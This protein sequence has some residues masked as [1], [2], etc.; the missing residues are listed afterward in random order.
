MN[1]RSASLLL[2]L[3]LS[4]DFVF[5]VLHI[6]ILL[7]GPKSS[8]CDISGLCAYLNV[9][10][11]LK[12]FWIVVLLAYLLRTT[13]CSGYISW[14]V[15]FTCFLFD[16]ALQIHQN[17]GDQIASISGPYLPYHLILQPR[18][19]ELALLAITG[20]SLLAIVAWVYLRST[21][22]FRKMSNDILLFIALLVF[23]GLIVDVATA[24]KLAPPIVF[25]L[26]IVEDGGEMVV[27]SLIVWYV[28]LLAISSGKPDLYLVDRLRI[29]K[30]GTAPD[31]RST[32]LDGKM[33]G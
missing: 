3:L 32:M 27:D 4:V 31:R 23:F 7:L 11:L 8:L 33:R 2:L 22:E 10:H 16:D 14:I 6:V 18:Y 19:F 24:I 15:M 12:L 26:E 29:S 13:R 21:Y 17:I 20:I 30:Q 28:F 9:Y 5:I 25:A 1:R